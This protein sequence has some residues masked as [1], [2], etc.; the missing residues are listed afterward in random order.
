MT[1]N[2]SLPY[3]KFMPNEALAWDYHCNVSSH[4][5]SCIRQEAE[6]RHVDLCRI[7]KIRNGGPFVEG[8]SWQRPVCGGKCL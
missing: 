7:H 5:K 6:L 3:L 8:M 1:D 4:I 2:R